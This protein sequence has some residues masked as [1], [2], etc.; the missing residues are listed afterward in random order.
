MKRIKLL[1]LA[2]LCAGSISFAQNKN[3]DIQPYP[4]SVD[5]VSVTAFGAKGDG[6]TDDT[7]AFQ[8]AMDSFG[9]RGG[10]A[11]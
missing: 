10:T 6:M 2:L 3:V 11:Y 4:E 9:T 8:K 7:Q 1:T 5:V